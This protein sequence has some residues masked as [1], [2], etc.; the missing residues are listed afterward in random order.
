MASYNLIFSDWDNYTDGAGNVFSLDW[1]SA[2]AILNKPVYPYVEAIRQALNER[3]VV[4]NR[5]LSSSSVAVVPS[6]VFSDGWFAEIVKKAIQYIRTYGVNDY[7]GWNTET[8]GGFYWVSASAPSSLHNVAGDIPWD[9]YVYASTY[10]YSD[11]ASRWVPAMT[12]MLDDAGI[13]DTALRSWW[14]QNTGTGIADIENDILWS[15]ADVIWSIKKILQLFT[16]CV[17]WRAMPSGLIGYDYLTLDKTYYRF[18]KGPWS[19]CVSSLNGQSWTET[20]FTWGAGWQPYP[21]AQLYASNLNY[22]CH[23]AEQHT[24]GNLMVTLPEGHAVIRTRK[25]VQIQFYGTARRD[26]EVSARMAMYNPAWILGRPYFKAADFTPE[27]DVVQETTA[28]PD[29]STGFGK[30]RTISGQ[31][32]GKA[33]QSM[34][35]YGDVSLGEYGVDADA[36]AYQGYSI[37]GMGLIQNFNVANGFVFK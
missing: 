3:T 30:V 24:E 25:D 29:P 16:R 31:S 22:A 7:W 26:V 12:R 33:A 4:S 13:V 6:P 20:T 1:S 9:D 34:G 35:N 10:I 14:L 28:Y 19:V 8:Y 27:V 2:A 18:A 37:T 36:V 23:K 21:D 11:F 5:H 17:E 15:F 32:G